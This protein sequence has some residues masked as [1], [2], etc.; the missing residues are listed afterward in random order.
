MKELHIRD[1]R[2]KN[3][4]YI[5]NQYLNGYAKILGSI[6]TVTYLSLCRHADESEQTC[7]PQM[8]T[9]AEENGISVKSVER[10]I[11]KLEEWN[12]IS[13]EKRKV[14]GRQISN[15][16]TLLSKSVWA[17][18]PTDNSPTDPQSLGYRQTNTAS[19]DRQN[20]QTPVLHNNTNKQYSLN[21]TKVV[22][23]KVFKNPHEDIC[24][25]IKAMESIDMN[26]SKFYNNPVQKEA[27]DDLITFHGLETVLDF[28]PFLKNNFSKVFNPPNTPVTLRNNWVKVIADIGYQMNKNKQKPGQEV[29]FG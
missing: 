1:K 9:I 23:T 2:E 3:W 28:I 29:V 7:F 4:F 27:C 22:K 26:N 13:V 18:K 14:E 20:R 17:K 5:D 15:L 8:R 16:Y 6:C 21:K 25:I 10:A 24:K 19:T 12:I 11:K